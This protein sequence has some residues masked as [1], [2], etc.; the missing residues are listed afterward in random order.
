M[1]RLASVSGRERLAPVVGRGRPG[2]ET[3]KRR[4]FGCGSASLLGLANASGKKQFNRFSADFRGFV[5]PQNLAPRARSRYALKTVRFLQV[6]LVALLFCVPALRAEE[7]LT[8]TGPLIAQSSE[9]RLVNLMRSSWL[10]ATSAFTVSPS[11]TPTIR[12]ETP[13]SWLRAWLASSRA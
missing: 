6:I 8:L 5:A 7:A 2:R 13:A 9:S 4:R 3:T 12:A 10:P 11:M 1:C